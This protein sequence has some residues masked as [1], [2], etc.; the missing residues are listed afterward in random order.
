MGKKAGMAYF[1]KL[2]MKM[3]INPGITNLW[4]KI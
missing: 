2:S 3:I 1:K 4:A